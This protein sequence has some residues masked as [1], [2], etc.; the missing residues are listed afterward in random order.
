M[1]S[2]LSNPASLV[3]LGS[4]IAVVGSLMAAYGG[5]LGSLKDQKES[6]NLLNSL[7]GGDAYPLIILSGN[8]FSISVRGRFPLHDVTGQI[9]DVES[10]R[11]QQESGDW[12]GKA[13]SNTQYFDLGTLSPAYGLHIL[14]RATNQPI[15]LSNFKSRKSYRFSI[16]LY[17]RHHIY[18]FRLALEP[19]PE[20]KGSFH[21]A[22]QVYRDN[23]KEP[24]AEMVPDDFPLNKDNEVDFLLMDRHDKIFANK[25]TNK[26]ASR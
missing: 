23:D 6:Q 8:E 19:Y 15:K 3:L 22:W 10:L 16:N 12:I 14:N 20:S 21:Q 7:T 9:M 17:T 18:S 11:E 13:V 5:Y 25:Q 4:A 1:K 24:M 2:F 26:D